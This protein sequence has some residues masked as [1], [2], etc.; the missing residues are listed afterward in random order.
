M[1]MLHGVTD[2]GMCW[3]RVAGALSGDYDI[4]LLDAR[5]HGLS[6]A[7]E[8][9]YTADDHAA[10]VAGA[11]AALSLD[12]PVLF[13]HS[14]GARTS[15]SA[16]ANY[17]ELIR[18]IVLED[19]PLHPSVPAPGPDEAAAQLEQRKNEILARRKMSRA[20]LV[21]LARKE[22]PLWPE[23]E[24]GPWAESKLQVSPYITQTFALPRRPWQEILAKVRCPALLITG[25]PQ[26]YAI[27]TPE[28]AKEAADLNPLVRVVRIGGAGHCI[29]RDQ[30]EPTLHAVRGFLDIVLR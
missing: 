13:G 16:A 19:P 20:E 5:G 9:G 21:A 17:P 12:R 2:N 22:N 4:I 3:V 25:D 30:F 18:A 27:V 10:D 15:L 11:I 28:T 24:L 8:S 26:K 29:H 23:E 7:P 14:M 6:D 1:V